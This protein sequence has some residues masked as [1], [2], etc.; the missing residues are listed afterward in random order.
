MTETV[1]GSSADKAGIK[2]GDVITEVNGKPI[3]GASD[4]R[5]KISLM[6]IGSELH[7]TVIR[8][9][10]SQEITAVLV[11]AQSPPKSA[12]AARR[13]ERPLRLPHDIAVAGVTDIGDFALR[14]S[15]KNSAMEQGLR[16]W[17]S[18]NL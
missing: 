16:G 6:P 14:F 2:A 11:E 10:A 8:K 13:V 5:S 18:A 1:A 9:G 17:L 7:I 15:H 12:P 4:L 3:S